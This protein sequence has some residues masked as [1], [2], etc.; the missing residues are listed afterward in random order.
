MNLSVVIIVAMVM[1]LRDYGS[2][3]IFMTMCVLDSRVIIYGQFISRY[4]KV[5]LLLFYR[6]DSATLIVRT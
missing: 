3:G 2:Y 1:L 6:L 5:S 4:I